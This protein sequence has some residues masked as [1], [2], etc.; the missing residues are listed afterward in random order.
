LPTALSSGAWLLS[1]VAA[2]PVV[3]RVDLDARHDLGGHAAPSGA[4]VANLD[5]VLLRQPPDRRAAVVARMAGL[6]KMAG[7]GN[8]APGVRPG[9]HGLARDFA[10]DQVLALD[11]DALEEL[12]VRLVVAPRGVEHV[13]DLVVV[14]EGGALGLAVC[15]PGQGG[16]ARG[17]QF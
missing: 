5:A 12:D 11:L 13:A 1:S 14:D 9:S 7:Q 4:H 8:A 3:R 15:L 6:G 17:E 2:R 10:Q 16:A